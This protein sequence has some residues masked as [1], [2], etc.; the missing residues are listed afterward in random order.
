MSQ[1][2]RIERYLVQRRRESKLSFNFLFQD[3][4]TEKC[5]AA[6]Q[7]D[8]S[9]R[10][11]ELRRQIE[12]EAGDERAAKKQELT[13][14]RRQYQDLMGQSNRAN[15]EYVERRKKGRQATRH[16]KSCQKCQLKSRAQNL[17]ITVHEWPLPDVDVE[18]KSAVFELDVPTVISRWRDTTYS[19]LV[20][21]CSPMPSL[22]RRSQ[23][24][25]DREMKYH[26]LGYTGLSNY[27]ISRRGRL[28][29][30]S[31]AKPFVVSHYGKKK[32]SE[33]YRR[34]DMCQ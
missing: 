7:F 33:S 13:E 5:F 3:V 20:D 25:M 32:V 16:S 34:H 21:I 14:K 26:L 17:T 28:Q 1:L 4:N 23:Q 6:R 19:I 11:K 2:D 9:P 24:G 10:H 31:T 8:R 22:F 29:L 18:A 30:G 27:A 15:C 12:V